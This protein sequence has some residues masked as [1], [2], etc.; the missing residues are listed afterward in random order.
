MLSMHSAEPC[1]IPAQNVQKSY[2]TRRVLDRRDVL[3]YDKSDSPRAYRRGRTMLNEKGGRVR[4]ESLFLCPVCRRRLTRADGRYRCD[5]GHSF[6]TAAEGY[7]HLL[8]ANRMHSR[9]PGD[10]RGMAAARN[11]FLTGGYYAPLAARLAALCLELAP[12]GAVC[13]DSGC[14]EGYYTAQI[15]E[16]LF[17]A[18]RAPR[19]AGIDISKNC[20]RWA[21]K[22]EHRVEFAVA[23]AYALPFADSAADLLLNCFS[24]LALAEFRRV[25]KPGGAFL[26][27]VPGARHLWEL[28]QILYEKPYLNE[29]Q[30]SPYE[31]FRYLDILNVEG[32]AS[33]PS[34]EVIHD[35]FAMTPYF[36]KTPKAGRERLASISQLDVTTSFRIHLFQKAGT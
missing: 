36:W 10:D 2:K 6:D 19:M 16:A 31:G 26:Y 27:V 32:A 22:R 24:P 5:E 29:E 11:R 25:L 3:R 4:M 21:A 23:S 1:T 28:K 9:A 18:G 8:P 34:Q 30:P 33:L 20:L 14:G 7:T 15:A 13:I 35:L 17:A 12:Q